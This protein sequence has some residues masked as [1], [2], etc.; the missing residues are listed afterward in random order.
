[1]YSDKKKESQGVKGKLPP[2]AQAFW[3]H[4]Q[5]VH[6]LVMAERE[7]LGWFLLLHRF[8][9][10]E[11]S[12]ESG[13]ETSSKHEPKGVDVPLSLAP[14]AAADA[15][16]HARDAE[17]RLEDGDAKRACPSVA[18]VSHV[19]EAAGQDQ[20][21]VSHEA[22]QNASKEKAG[23]VQLPVHDEKIDGRLHGHTHCWQDEGRPAAHAVA[24]RSEESHGEETNEETSQVD[25][26][27]PVGD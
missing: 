15:G 20:V 3:G 19:G 10:T 1:M 21:V 4:V 11:S 26:E 2:G 7:Q 17:A 6:S 9:K 5:P 16:Q 8:L 27:V 14:L 25:T 22:A 18:G 12:V 13:S 23:N 24:P